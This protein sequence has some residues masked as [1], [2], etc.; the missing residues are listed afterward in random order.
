MLR[1]AN[2]VTVTD[3][4]ILSF[5]TRHDIYWIVVKNGTDNSGR[6]RWHWVE[7]GVGGIVVHE[8]GVCLGSMLVVTN[9]RFHAINFVWVA[10][11]H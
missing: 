7:L 8:S 3:T 1:G 10:V 11:E 5:A 4:T 9:K 2:I 6:C